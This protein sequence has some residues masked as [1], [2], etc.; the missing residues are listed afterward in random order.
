MSRARPAL[1]RIG[2]GACLAA[3]LLLLA[4]ALPAEADAERR[5]RFRTG[6]ST[7]A[8]GAIARDWL[9]SEQL[10]RGVHPS[11]LAEWREL[12]RHT[13]RRSGLEY[14]YLRQQIGGIDVWNSDVAIGI[15]PDG[16][17]VGV[18]ARFVWPARVR[19][20]PRRPVLDAAQAVEAAASWLRI[21]LRG[22]PAVRSQDGGPARRS[23]VSPAGLTS[24]DVEARLMYLEAGDGSL[25]LVW[26]FDLPLV[27]GR[28]WWVMNVD[29]RTG[30]VH[31]QLD[32]VRQAAYT[33]YAIPKE[34]PDDG[35]RTV[36]TDPY[37]PR[38]AP[39]GWHD[40]N[41]TA[42]ADSERSEGLAVFA[43][44]NSGPGRLR[45]A[46]GGESQVF[47]F[48]HDPNGDPAAYPEAAVTNL[49]Y[50]NSV[51]HDL[52]L[53]YGFDEG[54][55]NFQ[56]ISYGSDPNTVPGDDV[57]ALAQDRNDT[58][59]ASMATPPDGSSPTMRMY[60][61]TVPVL[62][63]TQPAAI[64]ARYEAGEALF[65]PALTTTGVAGTVVAALDP[66]DG[67]GASTFDACSA[68]TN[69][70]AVSGKVA[71]VDRGGCNFVDK[72]DNA[73]TAGAIGVIVANNLDGAVIP[74]GAPA[75]PNPTIDIPSLMVR[76]SV[77]ASIRAELAS[78]TVTSRLQLSKRDSDFDNGVI[79]H[80]F[81]HG[82]STRLAG[83]AGNASCLLSGQ[84]GGM[85]EGWSDFWALALTAKTG[86][87]GADAR[88]IGS[89][90]VGEPGIRN[91]P[92][93]TDL[94]VNPQT[95]GD[96]G[97]ASG[98]H[99][100]GE[101]WA[102]SLWEVYW[103]LVE[104]FGFE[105]DLYFG[106]GG[107]IIALELVTG[108]LK[109][110]PCDPSFI[111]ARDAILAADLASHGQAH[112][113]TIWRGFA[114][115]GLG[116]GASGSGLNPTEDF[117]LPDECPLCGDSDTDGLVTQT[118]EGAIRTELSVPGTFSSEELADCV[119]RSFSGACGIVEVALL[120]RGLAGLEPGLDQGCTAA[121]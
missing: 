99:A 32:R 84:A 39:F 14:L 86:Q 108:G 19:A 64:D 54:A 28:H 15:T 7:R 112:E 2:R 50:W 36:E 93:S 34:S 6:P 76:K 3:S 48:L 11:E 37:D 29:A 21:P 71:L 65:G 68:L 88:T 103:L 31:T 41:G 53:R 61:W 87:D 116:Y 110:T 55:G 101:M 73:E 10:A 47:H 67:S 117:A 95:F 43:A 5:A 52:H 96:V 90:L 98:P 30:H 27:D 113:C 17:L 75:P 60:L 89:Y 100:I 81:G 91:F 94:S 104:K 109:L 70:G 121:P 51:L 40:T 106:T 79:V 72:V 105:A 26:N 111:D 92:Y 63:V 77:G 97:T 69:P 102:A 80:E 25:S 118:D 62:D 49:F 119:A 85:G 22:R 58:N 57:T 83:G 24:E 35:P 46:D 9:R 82:V 38:A 12:S 120:R 33:V 59:N 16:R 13:G 8:P 56:I 23:V 114:K 115:R 42:G 74:M 45:L 78:A 44:D 66:S 18:R 1:A 20:R 107:N 4:A